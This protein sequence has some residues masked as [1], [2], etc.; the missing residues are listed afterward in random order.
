MFQVNRQRERGPWVEVLLW[1]QQFEHGVPGRREVNRKFE[2]PER[3]RSNITRK[4][5]S[6]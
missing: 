4:K 5:K 1:G 6:S 2:N 3:E